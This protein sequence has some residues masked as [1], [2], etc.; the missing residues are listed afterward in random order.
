MVNGLN[1]EN[2]NLNLNPIQRLLNGQIIAPRRSANTHCKGR[3]KVK[4]VYIMRSIQSVGP[5]KA[6]YTF[7]P[8]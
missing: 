6:L 1:K 2:L 5:L 4:V 7:R 8:P 3:P